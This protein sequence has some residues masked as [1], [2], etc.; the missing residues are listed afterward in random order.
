MY[1]DIGELY[2]CTTYG[3]KLHRN[4]AQGVGRSDRQRPRR[5]EEITPFKSND[6][7]TL[8]LERNFSKDIIVRLYADFQIAARMIQRKT[9]PRMKGSRLIIDWNNLE[10]F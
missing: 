9:L 7:V 8:N 4:Y 2:A 6:P 10:R 1:G 5:G 3:L